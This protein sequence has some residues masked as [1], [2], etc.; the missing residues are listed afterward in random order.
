MIAKRLRPHDPDCRARRKLLAE[1]LESRAPSPWSGKPLG[2]L[3]RD[4]Q[5]FGPGAVPWVV[6]K[7]ASHDCSGVLAVR[8]NWIAETLHRQTAPERFALSEVRP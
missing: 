7:C 5:A 2:T 4:P 6:F 8:A 1:G 3:F